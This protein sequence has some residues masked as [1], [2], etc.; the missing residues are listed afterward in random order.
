MQTC[1]CICCICGD[2]DLCLPQWSVWKAVREMNDCRY[3]DFCSLPLHY[4]LPLSFLFCSISPFHRPSTSPPL[5]LFILL[6][7]TPTP[8]LLLPSLHLIFLVS[9]PVCLMLSPFYRTSDHIT[10]LYKR[11]AVRERQAHSTFKGFFAN[12]GL[13]FQIDL[14]TK[15][16]AAWTPTFTD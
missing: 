6:H 10:V 5:P 1:V 14:L 3:I 9:V 12:R 7:L 2:A 16:N 8:H 15:L 13:D 4:L 11:E